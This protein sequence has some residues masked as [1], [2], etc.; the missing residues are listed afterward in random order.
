[1]SDARG[2]LDRISAFRQRLEAAPQIAQD[3]PPDEAPPVAVAEPE[4]FRQALRQIAGPELVDEGPVP[5]QL[6]AR[7]RRL[8]QTAKELLDRQRAF[9]ADPVFAGL[10]AETAD[11]DPLVP[12][13]KE[14][15]AVM[16][17]QSVRCNGP[18]LTLSDQ[19]NFTLTVVPGTLMW[20][21]PSN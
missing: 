4:A 8:L 11:P 17:N 1:M 7:T 9:T 20:T 13:H 12:Y 21:A 19:P 10:A 18:V 5:P 2:L 14:T 3:S 6:T 16:S 15:T